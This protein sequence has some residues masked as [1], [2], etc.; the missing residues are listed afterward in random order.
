MIVTED[1]AKMKWCPESRIPLPSGTCSANRDIN[2]V[3]NGHCIGSA[4]MAWRPVRERFWM[5]DR[6]FGAVANGGYGYCGKA[7]RP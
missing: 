3:S 2:N 6:E 1:E 7:G 4:C 5:N